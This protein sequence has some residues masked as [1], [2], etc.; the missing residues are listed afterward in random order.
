MHLYLH[1]PFCARR[2]SYCDFAIAVRHRDPSD[3]YLGAIAA[4][5]TV[6][7]G[8]SWLAEPAP[9]ETIYF[10]GGTPS[11]IR[12][13]AVGRLL[14]LLRRRFPVAPKAEVT[15]E[16][17]PE[18][19]DEERARGWVAAGV[20][21]VSLGV[22]SFD[23]KVLAWMHR[24]HGPDRPAAAVAALRA[25]GIG[26]LSIDLIYAVPADLDR[27]WGRDL[28]SGFALG[29]DHLSL[30][31]LT[32]E[33]AT[34]LGKWVDRGTTV[35]AGDDPAADEYLQAGA[36]FRR[37]GWHHYE[38]S[39]AARPGFESRHN[40]AYWNRQP[41]LGLGPSA[42]SAAGNR[43]WWNI[44]DWEAYRRGVAAGSAVAGEERLTPAQ[45]RLEQ[46]YLALRTSQGVSAS[47]LPEKA[48]DQ[49]VA[50]GWAGK[51][52]SQVTLTGLGWLR[53]DALVHQVDGA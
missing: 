29:P 12:P 45:V 11:R 23:P 41:Y 6:V 24:V 5:L 20:N 31:G 40:W 34:A 49:W 36:A 47:T 38:V 2:C 27:D 42:H 51:V 21:R 15:L 46:V 32:V 43:R 4:E 19:V 52:G 13:E 39:N 48:V 7:A 16:V 44:R 30:Y 8:A 3:D 53:L 22:Q 25:A 37:A 35:P 33:P 18:D 28:A 17:N 10:G 50:A 1:V 14:E 26:N 9:V